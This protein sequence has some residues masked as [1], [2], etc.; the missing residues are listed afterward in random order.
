[1]CDSKREQ[2]EQEEEEEDYSEEELIFDENDLDEDDDEDEEA[3]QNQDSA[4]EE[5]QKLKFNQLRKQ[6]G[7]EDSRGKRKAQVTLQY[8]EELELEGRQ[9]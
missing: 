9:K 4:R 3:E 6:K 1:M 2:Q 7:M 5:G 8:E